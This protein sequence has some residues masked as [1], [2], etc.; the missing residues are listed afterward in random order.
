MNHLHHDPDVQ[1]ARANGGVVHVGSWTLRLPA[2]FGFC[3][4]V[5][6]AIKQLQHTV[7]RRERGRIWLLGDIIHNDTV[8]AYFKQL[9]VRILP[10]R[11][12]QRI[13][14]V[15]A[16][17]DVVVI[18]AFGIPKDLDKQL[19]ETFPDEQIVD[20]TCKYVKNIWEFVEQMVRENRTTLIHGKPHHPETLAILSRALSPA[21]ATVLIP[22]TETGRA[23]ADVMR[24]GDVTRSGNS[25]VYNPAQ[26]RTDR[27]ALVNQ[28]T[29]L[30]SE[31]KQIER[32]LAA[33]AADTN[34][35]FRSCETICRATQQR[36]DAT[37][38][39][40]REGCDVLL[41]IGGYTSSNTNQLYKVARCHAR[42]YFI[43]NANNLS[44][45]S[46][47]HYLPDERREVTAAD[48]LSK[49]PLT[50]GILAGASCP[51][52]DIGDVIR[53]F[54]RSWQSAGF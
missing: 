37:L 29:M 5:L 13:F 12:I 39:L 30:Y 46:I 33:A 41:I 11:G 3:G 26:L 21:T 45:D 22:D 14:D 53:F 50:I 8:N 32:E 17:D 20:A 35:D 10:E 1:A 48:W 7:D 24:T 52:S 51:A 27:L 28:T 19:R 23:F 15:A 36:Q 25:A 2:T 18:P 16:R 42:T 43:A 6:N 54:R 47:R 34:A 31:T 49:A 38:K 40:C 4:G 44:A 9:G